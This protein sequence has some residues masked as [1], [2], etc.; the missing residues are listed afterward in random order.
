MIEQVDAKTRLVGLLGYPVE[1]SRS[2]LIHNSA[3]QAQGLNCLYV[4][5]SVSSDQL[6]SAV[7]G[8]KALGFIGSN[9]TIPH[10]QTV[11]PLMDELSEQAAAVGAVNTIVCRPSGDGDVTILSGDNTDIDGFL[12]PLHPFVEKLIGNAML[13]FGAGGAAR[14]VAYALL[15]SYRPS[16]L[17]LAVRNVRNAEP[18]AN[19][20]S[21]FDADSAL[22]VI[23][24]GNAGVAVQRSALLV[25]ATPLGMYPQHDG[26]PWRKTGDFYPGQIVYDLVYNPPQT[27]LL[28]EADVAGAVTIGGLEMLIHQAA[29]SYIQWTG[30]AMPIDVV[31]SVLFEH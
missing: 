18:L 15:K 6:T 20:L 29:A 4:A 2:P 7:R 13:I 31:R 30:K 3:F 27:R 14:A 5:L 1:H 21:T 9:V 28:R 26:T 22:E 24:L 16:R 25:N 8:L 23:S 10:K 19:D 12:A 11:V 17:T